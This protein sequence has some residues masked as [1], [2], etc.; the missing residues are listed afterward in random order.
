MATRHS[1]RSRC[2]YTAVSFL[3]A[4]SLLLGGARAHAQPS[5]PPG[6]TANAAQPAIVPPQVIHS[7]EADYPHDALAARVEGSVILRLTIDTSGHV[8]EAEVVEPVG[9]GFDE[10]AV[11]AVRTFRFEPARR[12]G[13]PVAARIRFRYTFRLPAGAA[14]AESP[15]ATATESARV[16]DAP[17]PL[18]PRRPSRQLEVTVQGQQSESQRLRQSAEAVTIISTHRANQQTRDLGEVLASVEGVAV[19]RMG[20]LG[21]FSRFSLNGLYDNQV[22]FFFDGLPLDVSGSYGVANVPVS[23]VHHVEIFRGVLPVRFGA[24]ALGGAVN[25]VPDKR[26]QSGAHVS[27][28]RGSFGTT[29]ASL[30]GLYH[31]APSGLIA[32]GHAWLDNAKNDYFIDVEI[33]SKTGAITPASVRRLHD[34][35]RSYGGALELGFVDKP[36]AQRL[37]IRLF[38]STHD[39]ELQHNIDM[40]VPFGEATSGGSV[41]GGTIQ[42]EQPLL[43]TLSFS[44]VM[45]IS[46][47]TIELV[48]KTEWVYG[49]NSR[50]IRHR[51][52]PGEVTTIPHDST[53]WQDGVFGRAQLE[54]RALAAQSLRLASTLRYFNRTGDERATTGL[55]GT[56]PLAD[57]RELLT[58]MT[59]IEHELKA[60][61]MPSAD[62]RTKPSLDPSRA[63]RLQNVV[64][65]KH[66]FYSAH[67]ENIFGGP[68]ASTPVSVNVTTHRFG[69]GDG[70]R[71]RLAE[72][73]FAK[74]SYELATRL[75]SVEELYGDGLLIYPNLDLVP[76]ASHNVNLGLQLQLQRTPI[77]VFTSE[78]NGFVRLAERLIVQVTDALGSSQFKNISG[79]RTVGFEGSA[80]W[81]SPGGWVVLDGNAT[82]QDSRNTSL[83]GS[84]SSFNG[85][86]LP[87]RPWLF[88][89]WSG[90]IQWRGALLQ[91]DELSPF[92][93]GRYVHEFFRSWESIGD[94]KFKATIPTQIS[95]ALG[96]SYSTNLWPVRST[97]TLE[98]DNVTDAKLYDF[99]SVQRPGRSVSLRATGEFN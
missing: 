79:A 44:G 58:L 57:P 73:L 16:I 3:S 82:W 66:Y 54:W 35:Y 53:I 29:R 76:E 64:F 61:D 89:N 85:D 74:A 22:R 56:D 93:I 10:A 92:Y 27:Y 47:R 96:V 31:H 15:K 6:N 38:G 5:V 13:T 90:R 98:V 19:R 78:V 51:A 80:S 39:K 88:A 94:P 34:A 45:G 69:V 4:I 48:D 63:H 37:L 32:G 36:W 9:H 62:D 55:G 46:R 49:W 99:F 43:K 20:G 91:D 83:E 25:L 67:A 30:G 17:K 12:G 7:P 75:P 18:P 2:A 65:A 81:R 70:V 41:Y 72:R 42:Y 77:G 8:V 59:G 28:Q 86:R 97:I 68:F 95:H 1:V 14:V 60:L 84:Y 11:K 26:Y 33:A 24:D 71:L 23:L 87:N 40:S 50:R 21:S 52:V